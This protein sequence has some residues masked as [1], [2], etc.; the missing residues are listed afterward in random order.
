M[1]SW[2][3][4]ALRMNA[5]V[6]TIDYPMNQVAAAQ[7]ATVLNI[8]ALANAVRSAYIPGETFAIRIIQDG[9]EAGAG[10]RLS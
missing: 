4:L 3:S 9:K 6:V 5:P 2:S 10:R 8:N 1:I 7:G